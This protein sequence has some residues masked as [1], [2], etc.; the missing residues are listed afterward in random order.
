MKILVFLSALITVIGGLN[1]GLIGF[2]DFNAIENFICCPYTLKIVYCVMGLAAVLFT[3]GFIGCFDGASCKCSCCSCKNEPDLTADKN[4]AVEV[5]VYEE[6]EED[7]EDNDEGSE[8][9]K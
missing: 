6:E 4:E 5:E 1:W 3:L 2:F 9:D 7:D 8:S